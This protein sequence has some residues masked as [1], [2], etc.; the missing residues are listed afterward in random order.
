MIIETNTVDELTLKLD[1]ILAISDLLGAV[2]NEG[3]VDSL[4]D[5]TLKNSL[6]EIQNITMA[7]HRLLSDV[8]HLDPAAAEA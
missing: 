5:G 7:C 3:V 4:L 2:A 1:G 8:K 6:N